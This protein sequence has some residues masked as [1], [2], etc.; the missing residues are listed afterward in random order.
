[1]PFQPLRDTRLSSKERPC[2]NSGK[3]FSSRS[4]QSKL[5][6]NHKK[7]R[8]GWRQQADPVF[9]GNQDY[10]ANSYDVSSLGYDTTYYW[11]IDEVNGPNTVKGNIWQFKTYS[12]TR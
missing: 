6:V 3:L 5:C 1:M 4:L 12:R 10:D 9:K 8:D 11:Q 7:K 2:C